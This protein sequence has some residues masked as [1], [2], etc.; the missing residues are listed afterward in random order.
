[1]GIDINKIIAEATQEENES[2]N[3]V[4]NESTNVQIEE[5]INP[6]HSTTID[7]GETSEMDTNHC[8][9]SAISAGLGAMTF[10]NH[11]RSITEISDKAKSRLKTAGKV[12]LGLGAA[13]LAA[14]QTHKHGDAIKGAGTS[15]LNKIK[16]S[17]QTDVG[18]TSD[19]AT[20]GRK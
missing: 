6:D 18:L 4:L 1:M 8:V 3:E 19:N 13:G 7:E 9:A 14:W 11:L 10:R 20:A 12:G 15:L 2:A 17:G 16:G 5:N